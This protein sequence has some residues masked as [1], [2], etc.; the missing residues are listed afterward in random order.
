MRVYLCVTCTTGK[1]VKVEDGWEMEWDVWNL[2]GWSEASE[3]VL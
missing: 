2:D 1:K 3:E